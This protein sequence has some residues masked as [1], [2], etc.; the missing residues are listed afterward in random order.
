MP[1]ESTPISSFRSNLG[2]STISPALILSAAPVSLLSGEEML[3]EMSAPTAIV[4][5]I[6][7]AKTIAMMRR[8]ADAAAT[9]CALR[10]P[11]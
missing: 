7:S 3:R 1:A 2:G 10:A 5:M 4:T 8:A 9:D 6:A 11:T